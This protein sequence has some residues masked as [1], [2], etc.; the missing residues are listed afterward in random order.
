MPTYAAAAG[1]VRARPGH[2]ALGQRRQALPRLP[3]RPRRHVARPRPPGGGRRPRPTRPARCCTCRTCSA[4]TWRRPRWPARI[5]R[6]LGGGGQVFFCNSRR[7][8]QRVRHQAGPQVGRPRHVRASSAPTARSTAAR[9]P[10]CTPPASRPSTRR[11][12]RCP[13]A[14]AT[15][16]G[17]TSTRSRRPSRPDGGRGAARA[18]AGRGRGEPGHRR[19]L[20]GR[21]PAVRRAGLLF[22]VDEVQTGLGRTGQWFGFEHFG[23]R[24]DV[25][26]HGQGARQRRARSVPAGPGATWPTPSSPATTARTFGGTPIATAAAR[27]VLDELAR[28][29]APGA[30]RR[31]GRPPR[32]RPG[33]DPRREGGARLRPAAGGRAG[34]ATTPRR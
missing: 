31:A 26:T 18:G 16:P 21:A 24:P 3:V 1:D 12:S 22:M 19:V 14:S 5:D 13:R 27:A 11:S 15:S 34:R 4:T 23:V 9:S 17:T 2:R 7:R 33:R 30:G 20:P 28:I 6:L 8:G 25:V 29:D 32:R 10:R